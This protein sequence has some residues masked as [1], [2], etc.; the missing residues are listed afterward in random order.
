V[1]PQVKRV[2]VI[3]DSTDRMQ[4]SVRAVRDAASAHQHAGVLNTGNT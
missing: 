3:G 4:E 2:V 1:A